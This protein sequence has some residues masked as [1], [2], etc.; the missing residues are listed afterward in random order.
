MQVLYLVS[1][2]LRLVGEGQRI[3]QLLSRLGE[4]GGVRAV[5]VETHSYDM[6]HIRFHP[7]RYEAALDE[8]LAHGD[9]RVV[10]VFSAPIPEYAALP[11]RDGVAYVYDRFERWDLFPSSWYAPADEDNLIRDCDGVVSTFEDGRLA[12]ARA[13][14]VIPN[15]ASELASSAARHSLPGRFARLAAAEARAVYVG[16][17]DGRYVDLDALTAVCDC[18]PTII[19]GRRPGSPSVD[20]GHLRQELG[21]QGY[22]AGWVPHHNLSWLLH[23]RSIGLVSFQD[24]ELASYIS[25]IKV[26]EYLLAGVRPVVL[27]AS[28]VR[29]I[30]WVQYAN[31]RGE[32]VELAREYADKPM[33]ERAAGKARA[34]VQEVATW[35]ARAQQFDEFLRGLF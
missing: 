19:G 2:P 27:N 25:P 35:K 15:G 18:V 20:G 17:L 28:Q 10:V 4:I 33:D 16:S 8:A 3:P 30:P 11:R 34:W 24:L 6:G 26:Y 9:D 22:L 29:G 32:F 13:C 5:C 23:G 1:T 31:S 21:N 14:A 7:D 12:E